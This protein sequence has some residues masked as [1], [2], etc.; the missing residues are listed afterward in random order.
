[1]KICIEATPIGV[2]SNDKGGVYRYISNLVE[3]LSCIDHDDQYTLFFN[4]FRKEHYRSLQESIRNL[5]LGDNFSVKVSRF[6]ARF[7]RFIEPPAEFL[8]GRF[9][10]FHGCF[11][12]LRP[13]LHGKGVVTI[14]DIRYLEDIDNST[15]GSWIETVRSS[16]PSPDSAVQDLLSR[17]TLFEH[18]RSTI[19]KT[20]C[21]ADMVIT[22][23]EFS[24]NRI[25]DKLGVPPEKVKVIYHGIGKHFVP[26]DK[27]VVIPVLRKYGIDAP[28]I[29]YTGKFE[30]LKNLG[31]LLEAFQKV[32]AF[33]DVRL[34]LAG[35]ENWF[36]NVIR[37]KARH[38]NIE[39]KIICT[40]FVTDGELTALYSGAAVF[41][42]PSL[43][44]GFGLPLLEAM[45]CGAPIVT[46]NVCSIPEVVS[47][48][49]VFADP[50][51]PEDIADKIAGCL[52]NEP[53]RSAL[54]D[55]GIKQA[56]SFT[57]R[58]TAFKTLKVYSGLCQ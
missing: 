9:D 3:T 31:R 33:R 14:H 6:P 53:L 34:V 58:E 23:S 57:W 32:A 29:L 44:E 12:Y 30:P 10:V 2:Q 39:D 27:E 7:Q 1:M 51:S 49:A 8:A 50:Y 46:S 45:A 5:S 21:R 41:A 24:R 17:D 15:D 16:S 18:L 56:Q 36:Y 22:V 19:K 28:Y 20:V 37:E 47:D 54:I 38:M 4:F 11:D 42:F 13:I 26:Q 40:G 25:I 48:A 52:E 35:P 55:K 43:Y